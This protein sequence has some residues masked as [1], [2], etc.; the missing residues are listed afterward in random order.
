MSVRA[1]RASLVMAHARSRLDAVLA[2]GMARLA[3]V[4]TAAGEAKRRK[5]DHDKFLEELDALSDDDLDELEEAFAQQENPSGIKRPKIQFT[6]EGRELLMRLVKELVDNEG[7]EEEEGSMTGREISDRMFEIA[8]E[9]ST[10]YPDL[11]FDQL[12]QY[13]LDVR[14]SLSPRRIGK[15]MTNWKRRNDEPPKPKKSTWAEYYR[16]HPELTEFTR[17]DV[18]EAKRVGLPPKPPPAPRPPRPPKPPT[19]KEQAWMTP[20]VANLPA[21]PPIPEGESSGGK[22]PYSKAN[23]R[24]WTSAEN[25]YVYWYVM[26]PLEYESPRQRA[27]MMRDLKCEE[28]ELFMRVRRIRQY[29]EKEHPGSTTTPDLLNRPDPAY[30]RADEFL[31]K[32]LADDPQP[33]VVSPSPSS[34]PTLPAPSPPPARFL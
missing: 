8:N 17:E 15:G 25:A 24:K 34:P 16:E 22:G 18:E 30:D 14:K 31:E 10:R 19:P 33:S 13:I 29:V 4:P 6:K 23:P 9:L 1:P 5:Q 3:L 12:H 20:E 28:K 26:H 27:R 11:E 21:P 2:A 32:V 7:E